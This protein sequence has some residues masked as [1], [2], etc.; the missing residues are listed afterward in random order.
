MVSDNPISSVLEQVP[1]IVLDG[2]L[3]TELE[4]RGADLSDPLWSARAL[5]DSPGLIEQIHFD[6]FCSGADVAVSAS[7]QCTVEGFC[8]RGLGRSE[9]ESLILRFRDEHYSSVE[10]EDTVRRRP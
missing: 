4:H 2:G 5:I 8:R 7:Y 1:C 6:Y 9:A 3:G 10:Q